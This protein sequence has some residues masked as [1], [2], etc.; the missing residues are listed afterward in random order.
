M[1]VGVS[2]LDLAGQVIAAAVAAGVREIVLCP[3][4]RSAP[5]AYAAYAAEQAGLV[6][7]H[8]RV[9]ERSAAFLALGLAKTTRIP[10]AV[11][12]TSGTAVANLHPAVLEAHHAKVPLLV[13]SA[14]RP[15]ALRD[16]GANQTTIQP[17]IFAG[18][19]RHE[20]DLDD[21]ADA[22]TEL[23]TAY[24]AAIGAGDPRGPHGPGRPQGRPRGPDP[25]PVHVNI[26]LTEPL[27]PQ[28]WPCPEWLPVVPR[29]GLD[30]G[31][32]AGGEVA[33]G[34]PAP[35]QPQLSRPRRETSDPRV[36]EPTPV[37][38]VEV[39]GVASRGGQGT[40][41]EGILQP[42]GRTLVLLG[43]LVDPRDRPRVL[44]W[45][46][47]RGHPVI[48]E[49]FGEHG[50][51]QENDGQAD[52]LY[53]AGV[54]P[55]G[56]LVLTVAS[57]LAAHPPERIITAGRLTLSRPVAALLRLPGV[58][59]EALSDTQRCADPAG[60][61]VRAY[62]LHAALAASL[63]MRGADPD[64][65]WRAAWHE[66]GAAVA[67]AV[68]A[69]PP[70]WPTGLAIART[71]IEALPERAILFTGPSNPV[72]D[73]DFGVCRVPAGRTV[74]ASRGL[75]GIDGCVASAVGIALAEAGRP[76][77]ALL[78]DLTFLH[79][80]NGLLIGPEEPRPD[81]TIVVVN[82]EGG[83]IFGLLEPGRQALAEPYE[84]LFGTA[85][86]TDLGALTRAHGIV[87]Q[88]LTT[89]A[90]LAN[91]IA[92]PPDGLRVLEVRVDRAGHQVAHARLHALAAA[93]LA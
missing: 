54:L 89:A 65:L 75:A 78:G 5:L 87:H 47:R 29:P 21:R 59:V 69:E 12:T 93:A 23:S 74:V 67:A 25:G 40:S 82:D 61:V 72:R 8:V 57:L 2:A 37:V 26:C 63:P 46:A 18:A 34:S 71:L 52:A 66:A 88:A 33:P 35:H 79:D 90:E 7:L 53:E 64:A 70:I 60:V 15:A 81:L 83:G 43:D 85:T 73:L 1:I 92:R 38:E 31:P 17:G 80:A 3:G 50:G 39:P 55:H 11:I 22:A 68:A 56:P 24:A 28:S 4:S 20:A 16:S 42:G 14:D 91:A 13:L 51:G 6:R 36:Q 19:V 32:G 10:A 9:D 45:A 48:A 49:P 62:D 41:D 77:Y 84:R 27:V 76:A 44:D 58:H 30:L 86:G